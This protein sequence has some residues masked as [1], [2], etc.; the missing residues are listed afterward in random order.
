MITAENGVPFSIAAWYC[1]TAS[2]PFL[3]DDTR[4]P[5]CSSI[6]VEM[7]RINSS[8]SRTSTGPPICSSIN[9]VSKHSRQSRAIFPMDGRRIENVVPLP[10]TEVT[11]TCPPCLRI[12]ELTVAS[13]NPFPVD[14]VVKY[15]SNI[16]S[17]RLQRYHILD[18]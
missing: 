12:M 3:H 15:G 18:P 13:P 5:R 10:T 8:P 17:D 2:A 7:N 1:K 4:Y 14:F 11:Q 9:C 6:S 16:F